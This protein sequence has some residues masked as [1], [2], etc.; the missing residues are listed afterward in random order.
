M[1]PSHGVG[2]W[3]RSGK[4]SDHH[5]SDVAF[6]VLDTVIGSFND[7]VHRSS[8]AADDVDAT[9]RSSRSRMVLI[10][11]R[12]H[13]GVGVTSEVVIEFDREFAGLG[14]GDVA[15]VSASDRVSSE[16]ERSAG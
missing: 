9:R 11:C 4:Q 14:S 12:T 2:L 5:H 8:R 1:R 3:F 13:G 16:V 7:N 15:D 6:V 10:A